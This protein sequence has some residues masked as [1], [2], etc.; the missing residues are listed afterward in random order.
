MKRLIFWYAKELHLKYQKQFRGNDGL[1][2]CSSDLPT[3][4]LLLHKILWPHSYMFLDINLMYF[5]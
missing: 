5:Y 3:P 4:R 2:V 1:F